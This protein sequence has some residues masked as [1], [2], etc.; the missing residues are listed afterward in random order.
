[1]KR[2]LV[3]DLEN[4]RDTQQQLWN[5]EKNVGM[6]VEELINHKILGIT[7]SW[8]NKC[9]SPAA[10]THLRKAENEPRRTQEDQKNVESHVLCLSLWW[11]I[12]SISISR[13]ER[14][15]LAAN[16][17]EWWHINQKKNPAQPDPPTLPALFVRPSAEGNGL[18]V[19]APWYSIARVTAIT[20]A[21][22]AHKVWSM[23]KEMV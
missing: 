21:H 2:N 15:I 8:T 22:S 7:H 3:Q 1:M 14:S 5:V 12:I 4:P 13:R 18:R 17:N 10:K 11:H 16:C 23:S 9:D 19:D 20:S 6:K